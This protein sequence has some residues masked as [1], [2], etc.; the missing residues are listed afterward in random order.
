MTQSLRA[1]MIGA[2]FAGAAL[3]ATAQVNAGTVLIDGFEDVPSVTTNGGGVPVSDSYVPSTA[4]IGSS[5]MVTVTPVPPEVEASVQAA[6]QGDNTIAALSADFGGAPTFV[7]AYELDEPLDL[8]D[9]TDFELDIFSL[10]GEG[11]TPNVDFTVAVSSDG[12]N[13]ADLT[14]N[15]GDPDGDG[16]LSFFL[17]DFAGLFGDDTVDE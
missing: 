9:F 2:A 4:A 12:E 6:S 17:F 15:F 7:F 8:T 16:V 14:N 13:F 3:F 5:A 10:T 1:P 11:E